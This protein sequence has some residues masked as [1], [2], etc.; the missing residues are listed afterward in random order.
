LYRARRN[1]IEN[2]HPT[3]KPFVTEGERLGFIVKFDETIAQWI[4]REGHTLE[5]RGERQ[6]LPGGACPLSAFG[7]PAICGQWF[8]EEDV[9]AYAEIAGTDAVV[10]ERE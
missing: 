10:F 1:I 2:L 9:K 3:L 6:A 4:D 7:G 5:C 8:L